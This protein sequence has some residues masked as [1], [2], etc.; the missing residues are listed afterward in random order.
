MSDNNNLLSFLTRPSAAGLVNAGTW[1][2]NNNQPLFP[3]E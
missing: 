1:E 2:A 3:A